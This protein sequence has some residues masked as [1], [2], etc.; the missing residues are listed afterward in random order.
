MLHSTHRQFVIYLWMGLFPLA[1]LGFQYL[2]PSTKIKAVVFD[3]GGVLAKT[4]RE[5]VEEFVASSLHISSNEAKEALTELKKHMASGGDEGNFWVEYMRARGGELPEDWLEQLDESRFQ[6]LKIIPGTLYIVKELQK[7]GFQTA[8]LSNVKKRRASVKK[9]LGYYE[10][11]DPALFSYEIGVNK[12][13]PKAYS[14]LLEKLQMP[15]EA[16]LFIDNKSV[17]VEAAKTVGIDAILFQDANQ[18]VE[19]LRKRGINIAPIDPV[20]A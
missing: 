4:N 12:P 14:I 8:L 7:Q 10:L 18:L 9:R 3:F 15:S 17:N 20:D 11:F 13:D 19:E 6:A 16:V 5:E 2:P 1:L